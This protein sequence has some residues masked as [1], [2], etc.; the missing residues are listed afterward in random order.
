MNSINKQNGFTLVEGLLIVLI[1]SV[2]GFAGYTVWNNNQDNE[3]EQAETVQQIDESPNESA[4]KAEV[5]ISESWK[6]VSSGQDGFSVK[7]PDGWKVLN[8]LDSNWI[9]V[10]TADN[11]IFAKGAPAEVTGTE[12]FGTDGPSRVNIIRFDDDN[13]S[14]LDGDEENLGEFKAINVT[15]TKYYKK[16]PAEADEGIGAL[17]NQQSYTYKFEFGNSTTFITYNIQVGEDDILNIVEE[18]VATLNIK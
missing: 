18:M 2:I 17:P 16:Y 11:T 4:E 12:S 10:R 9:T 1:L 6:T 13:F 7:I 3:I 15:G 5:A 8:V 14:F